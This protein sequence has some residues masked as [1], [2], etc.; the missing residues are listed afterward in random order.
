MVFSRIKL[1]AQ[2]APKKRRTKN[3]LEL[4]AQEPRLEGFLFFSSSEIYGDPDPKSIPTPETYHGFVSSVG[5]RARYDEFK[6]LGETITTNEQYGIQTRIVRPF[7]VFGPGMRHDD[8]RVIPMFTF[9]APNG[10]ALPVHGDG[11]Q[12]GRCATS[13]MP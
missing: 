11:R 10:R 7:N 12:T 9:E 3:L 4:G 8:R 6:R 13:P 2:H 1:N 5:P